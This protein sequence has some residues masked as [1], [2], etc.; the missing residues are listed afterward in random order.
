MQI[1]FNNKAKKNHPAPPEATGLEVDKLDP[2]AWEAYFKE[3]FRIYRGAPIQYVLT[4]SYEAGQMTW[5]RNMFE[6]FKERRGRT[7]PKITA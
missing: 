2:E 6:E 3:F 5:T 7:I 1:K 4:D